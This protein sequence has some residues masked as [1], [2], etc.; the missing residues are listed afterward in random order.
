MHGCNNLWE[1]FGFVKALCAGED[2]KLGEYVGIFFYLLYFNIITWVNIVITI[3][4][5]IH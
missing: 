3:V 1:A 5:V 4:L 2:Q